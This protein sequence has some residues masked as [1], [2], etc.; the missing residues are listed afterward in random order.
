MR[1]RLTLGLGMG[2]VILALVTACAAG[3]IPGPTAIADWMGRQARATQGH[4]WAFAAVYVAAVLLML[5]ASPLTLAAG[6]LFG[7]VVGL[8]IV[9]VAANLGAALAFLIGRYLARDAVRRRVAR[10]PRFLAMDRAIAEQGWWF[11]ALLRLSPLVPFNVQNYLYGLTGIGFWPCVLT[12]LVAMLPGT[13][14]YVGLGAAGGLGVGAARGA[15]RSPAEWLLLGLGLLATL[16]V[17]IALA[18]AA[19]RELRSLEPGRPDPGPGPDD[20]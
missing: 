12:S 2:L 14:L 20:R 15:T 19:R 18:R 7:P 13:V 8:I 6:A 17:S 9:T 1:P 16:V 3:A 11:V 4:P 5:P 10:T